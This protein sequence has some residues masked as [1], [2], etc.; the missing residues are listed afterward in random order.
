MCP[1]NRT[2]DLPVQSMNHRQNIIINNLKTE[3]GKLERILKKGKTTKKFKP[4][5]GVFNL[6]K[7]TPEESLGLTTRDTDEQNDGAGYFEC[8]S[9]VQ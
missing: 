5:E 8:K 9:R 4:N 1:M 3:T 2:T 6:I 7:K